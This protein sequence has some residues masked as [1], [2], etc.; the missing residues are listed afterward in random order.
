MAFAPGR[1]GRV[2]AKG[3]C[4]AQLNRGIGSH[5]MPCCVTS[6]R[7][8]CRFVNDQEEI[9]AGFV[10][11][12]STQRSASRAYIINRAMCRSTADAERQ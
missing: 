7:A 12:E 4:S 3:Y 11:T 8:A 5:T 10:Q 9:A 2:N 1:A 6:V